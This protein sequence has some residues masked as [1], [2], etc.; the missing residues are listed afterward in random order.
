MTQIYI[1]MN[2]II[3]LNTL[4]NDI[5]E[6]LKNEF[7]CNLILNRKRIILIKIQ[8][9]SRIFTFFNEKII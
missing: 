9:I 1:V 2:Y 7:V 4:F 5:Y 3:V 6:I 8:I